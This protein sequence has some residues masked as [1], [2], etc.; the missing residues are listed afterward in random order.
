MARWPSHWGSGLARCSASQARAQ[1]GREGRSNEQRR[2]RC[3]KKTIPVY[4]NLP[5]TDANNGPALASRTG[6]WSFPAAMGGWG[7]SCRR[8]RLQLDPHC[9]KRDEDPR[10][11]ASLVAD[12]V[13]H[14]AELLDRA[15]WVE[16][17]ASWVEIIEVIGR[18]I[19][20]DVAL[21]HRRIGVV[22]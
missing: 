22:T 19:S 16:K 5:Y 6:T 20:V 11:R 13:A 10:L 14:E 2:Q 9:R 3:P 4:S 1:G 7:R 15:K 12:G 8:A 21:T 17:I 18:M